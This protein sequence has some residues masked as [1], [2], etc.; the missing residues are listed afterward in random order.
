MAIIYIK[1][2]KVMTFIGVHPWEK[3]IQQALYLSVRLSYDETQAATTDCLEYALDYSEVAQIMK[4][5]CETS[6]YQLLE[7]LA[8]AIIDVLFLNP[9]IHHIWLK[10][11]KPEAVPEL[12]DIG[13]IIE[14]TRG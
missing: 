6:Q 9:K 8:H 3:T 7:T 4:T 1:R 14:K 2:L 5:L 13:V 12:D 11:S 10:I